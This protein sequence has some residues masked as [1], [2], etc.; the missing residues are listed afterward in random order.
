MLGDSCGVLGEFAFDFVMA[1]RYRNSV[2]V[3]AVRQVS[4]VGNWLRTL[5][6]GAED[7]DDRSWMKR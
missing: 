1:Q 2:R 7:A 5:I 6:T 4:K 3:S